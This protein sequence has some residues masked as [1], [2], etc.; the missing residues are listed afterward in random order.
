MTESVLSFETIGSVARLTLNRP[1][2]MNSLN[3][4]M[5]TALDK[6]H[7]GFPMGSRAKLAASRDYLAAAVPVVAVAADAPVPAAVGT[8]PTSPADPGRLAAVGHSD[9]ASAVGALALTADHADARFRAFVVLAGDITTLPDSYGPRN[10]APL[11]A[12]SRSKAARTDA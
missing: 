6:G 5:L 1:K 8:L 11:L 2:A 10:A 4:A 12:A 7:G 3:L 9:G